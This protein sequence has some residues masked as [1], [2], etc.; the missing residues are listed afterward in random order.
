[1]GRRRKGKGKA[2]AERQ[3]PQQTSLSTADQS[4]VKLQRP[5]S[6]KK[7]T[8][9]AAAVAHSDVVGDAVTVAPS[10]TIAAVASSSHTDSSPTASPESP[11]PRTPEFPAVENT[12]SPQPSIPAAA[13]EASPPLKHASRWNAATPDTDPA[14]PSAVRK[15][16]LQHDS[17]SPARAT[18]STCTAGA[19]TTREADGRNT[20]AVPNTGGPLPNELFGRT[21]GGTSAAHGFLEPTRTGNERESSGGSVAHRS[22]L[23]SEFRGQL[24]ALGAIEP[25]GA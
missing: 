18:T 10:D 20:A 12:G 9:T 7:S 4:T 13:P 15:P 24:E 14:T 6:A 22:D 23:S 11:A 21:Y 17:G 2:H 16:G 25:T 5:A 3:D 1:M 8:S 19:S